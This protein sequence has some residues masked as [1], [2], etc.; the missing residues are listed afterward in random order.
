[1]RYAGGM[2]R[3]TCPECQ[4]QH[5]PGIL[6]KTYAAWEDNI[7][8]PAVATKSGTMIAAAGDTLDEMVRRDEAKR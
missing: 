3:P 8:A 6:C 1:M 5:G 7:W 2:Q 4:R